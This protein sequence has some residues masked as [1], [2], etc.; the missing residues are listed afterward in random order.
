M[1]GVYNSPFVIDKPAV[2]DKT[3]EDHL[4]EEF[5]VSYKWKPPTK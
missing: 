2:F 3:V 4:K 1:P 5:K